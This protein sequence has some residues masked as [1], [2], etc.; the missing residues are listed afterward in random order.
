MTIRS[1]GTSELSRL[2]TPH[3]T[4]VLL[5]DRC[6]V[7]L[8]VFP[9]A[10]QF[11]LPVGGRTMLTDLIIPEDRQI[12]TDAF[13]RIADGFVDRIACR[14]RINLPSGDI[15]VIDATITDP[16]GHLP[17]EGLLVSLTDV[18]RSQFTSAFRWIS[19]KI[20]I[21]TIEETDQV[22]DEVLQRTLEVT[23]LSTVSVFF[24][25]EVGQDF[26]LTLSRSASDRALPNLFPIGP[27][28]LCW[29]IVKQ[30]LVSEVPVV[31]LRDHDPLS[32]DEL[33][34]DDLPP[35]QKVIFVPALA[36][37]V[38]EGVISFGCQQADWEMT[39]STSDFLMTVAEL[40]AGAIGRRKSALALRDRALKDTLTGLANRRL[41]VDRLEDSLEKIR[42]TGT[43]VS[44]LFIDCD[45]FKEVNDT[46]GHEI[47]DALLVGIAER[48]QTVCRSGELIARFGGDEFVIM[49]ESDL[50]EAAVVALGERIV[51]NISGTYDCDGHVVSI[52]V[53]VGV[54][55]HHGDDEP[56]DAASMFRRA[57]VAM[58]RAK[59][60]GKDRLELFTEEMEAHTKNRFELVSDLRTA[61]RQ[62]TELALWY[63]PIVTLS[64]GELSGYEALVRWNHPTRGVLMP[65]AFIELAEESGL[66][67]DLGWTM[68]D[69]ALN[70][71]ATWRRDA[72]VSENCTVAINLSVRH[73]MAEGFQANIQSLIQ[74]SGVPPELIE[75]EV[76]ET[77]FADRIT[78]VPRLV[79]LRELGI[80]LSI[81]DFGT[82]YSSL[83]Y[84]RDLPVD[85]LKIDKSFVDGLG[86]NPKDG[87]L[88]GTLI[89]LAEQ[90]GL[91]TIAEGIE[92]ARQLETLKSLGCSRG[93]G[94]LLGRPASRVVQGQTFN[95]TS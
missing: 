41:L 71:L 79:R 12:A 25:A 87:S 7:L 83:S 51:E 80:K 75:L 95:Y 13:R 48:L 31:A 36:G 40:I 8:D 17:T 63:Q 2:G 53:S 4:V 59:R 52:T 49:V 82:G 62:Q 11:S 9:G 74:Q 70:D 33:H 56:I 54:A 19:R 29:P 26:V 37:D 65:G 14:V 94:Y 64:S 88:V 77:V 93:Q 57:D 86:S 35:L 44:L 27:L 68:I 78:V 76:T 30:T 6:G 58:Y 28:Q 32:W 23:K 60:L 5:I 38:V 21:A 22:L 42:R 10:E 15:R 73:I 20:A 81:D 46:H 24:A 72:V 69:M 16:E 91:D 90:L 50:P 55:V 67:A 1:D 85:I 18:T 89:K 66:I 39:R 92:E 43:W 47:G 61:V 84:L 45:G 34:L 3:K